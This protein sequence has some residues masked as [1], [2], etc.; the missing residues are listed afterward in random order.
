M[1]EDLWYKNAVIYNLDLDTFM[2]ASGD[3]IGDFEGLIRRLDYLQ[4]LGITAIWL[5][6]FQ[7]S[8]QRDNGYD[9]TDY[10]GVDP[11]YGSSG[12]F[13]EFIHQAKRRG[14]RVLIDLVINHTSID[15]RWFQEARADRDSPYRDWY[16]WSDKRP[17]DWNSGMVFPG[18]QESTWTRDSRAKA[19]YYHRFYEHQPDLN[20]ENPEVREEIRRV[21]GYWLEQ[22]VSG[23]RVDA[24]PFVIEL[25]RPGKTKV[26]QRFDYL[27][28][29]RRFRQWRVGDAIL[30]GEA[31]L[32]PKE[33]G[34]YFGD[35][36]GGLQM[37]FNFWVNQ[38]LFYA[39]AT[40]EVDPLKKA[41]AETAEL[42]EICQ[43]AHFLRNHDELD[44]GRLTEKQRERVYE[45]FAPEP[46]MRIYNRGIRRRLAPML[47]DWR[48]IEL[49]Y[50]VLFSLPGTPVVY[51]GDEIGMGE[52]LDL[53]ERTTVRTPMQWTREPNAGFTISDKPVHPVVDT[54]TYG[55]QYINVEAQRTDP[56][57][58]FNWMTRAI[59]VRKECPEIGWGKWRLLDV[60][61][62]SV[63]AIQYDW[64]GTSLITVHNFAEHPAEIA[65]KT[66]APGGHL[67]ADLFRHEKSTA[68]KNGVHRIALDAYGYHWYRVGGSNYAL[69]REK[70]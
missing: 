54:G 49:A 4:A 44:L 55:Y 20:M 2:D 63:L 13:I 6:P 16:I 39:L 28:V 48:H 58:L 23:F 62:P 34:R 22:G 10:Y 15:H 47:G 41:L 45:R 3:G 52:N 26:E 11:R 35:G 64:M 69:H 21:L 56:G 8:P 50:S 42:P 1:I 66:D 18:H 33:S 68:G 43:W 46:R 17:D 59:S 37:M 65:L 9:I 14:I 30:L 61:G 24:V 60:R 27:T 32:L 40:G 38:R 5:S 67:L 70:V 36:G 25:T 12:D 19:Y 31:N 57:S 51:Y 53:D 29:W 7:P